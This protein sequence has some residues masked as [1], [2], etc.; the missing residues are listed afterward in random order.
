[1]QKPHIRYS[2]LAAFWHWL[3]AA[4]VI[5]QF[6][7]GWLFHKVYERGSA[8]RVDMFEW[9]KTIG[10]ALILVVFLRLATRFVSTAPAQPERLPKW[11]RVAAVVSHFLLYVFLVAIPLGGL[12]AVSKGGGWVDLKFGL[13]FPSVPG[14]SEAVAEW[15]GEAHATYVWAFGALL[16]VHLLAAVYHQSR[17][18]A[19]AGRM[20]PFQ[21]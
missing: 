10:A 2:A 15:A 13:V 16:V 8:A 11:E 7:T 17:R 19:A 9:H 21:R 20:P 1:M 4:L 14:I 12:M 6:T 3:A 5:A 18:D